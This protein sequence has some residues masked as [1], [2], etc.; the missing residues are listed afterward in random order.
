[1]G[2]ERKKLMEEKVGTGKH[3]MTRKKR[4]A[5]EV[6]EMLKEVQE[7]TAQA[8]KET[9]KKS[10]KGFTEAGQ[11]GAA[12][13]SKKKGAQAEKELAE[14]SLHDDDKRQERLKASS[15]DAAGDGGLFSEERVAFAKKPKKGASEASEAP[16]KSSYE[17]TEYDP[18]KRLGKKKAHHAFKSRSKYKR[19]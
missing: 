19:R 15:S 18:N 8:E 12:R 6:R 1:M 10:N 3:R 7:E 13:A 17:F 5:Q 4:R 2:A 9:G 16:V 14:R 11:K